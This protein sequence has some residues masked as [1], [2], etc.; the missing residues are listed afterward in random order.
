[1]SFTLAACFLE[2]TAFLVFCFD[3]F[4]LP[5]LS[6]AGTRPAPTVFYMIPALNKS[7]RSAIPK[8]FPDLSRTIKSEIL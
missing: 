2:N 8:G 7:F 5:S 6:W 1:M 3:F 4:I